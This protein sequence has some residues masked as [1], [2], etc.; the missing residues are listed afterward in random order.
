MLLGFLQFHNVADIG[1]RA[2]LRVLERSFVNPV[3]GTLFR[4]GSELLRH[5]TTNTIREASEN[6]PINRGVLIKSAKSA[7]GNTAGRIVF[8]TNNITP[9]GSKMIDSAK[10]AA[11]GFGN[12]IVQFAFR[13]ALIAL[14]YMDPGDIDSDVVFDEIG[15]K[16]LS[17]VV[18]ASTGNFAIDTGAQIV[19]QGLIHWGLENTPFKSTVS[20]FISKLKGNPQSKQAQ[21][22]P[23]LVL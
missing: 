7:L 13:I 17:R 8:N 9:S 18:D 6:R 15:M 1:L 14:D 4:L 16:S 20:G 2:P 3:T 23:A 5:S 19:Q 10:R 22:D 12:I 21:A 11:I